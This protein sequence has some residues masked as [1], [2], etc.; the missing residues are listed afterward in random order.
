MPM[1]NNIVPIGDFLGVEINTT[2]ITETKT[3]KYFKVQVVALDLFNSVTLVVTLHDDNGSG[4]GT[5]SY[6]VDGAEY[7]A[8]NNDD[9]YLVNLVAQKL[10]FTITA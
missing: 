3:I 9:L 8:W 1:P 10:N 4:V 6:V 2:T 7:L 5:R